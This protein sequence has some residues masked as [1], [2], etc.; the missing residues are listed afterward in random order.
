[1]C[2]C[3]EC[4]KRAIVEEEYETFAP[5][6]GCSGTDFRPLCKEHFLECFGIH[7]HNNLSCYCCG[8]SL[9]ESSEFYSLCDDEFYCCLE[10]LIKGT[11]GVEPL[12][13]ITA[14]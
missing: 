10:C 2:K 7:K 14:P 13:D 4:E 9:N 5:S 12:E 6:Y 11:R 8:K 3:A 1:M